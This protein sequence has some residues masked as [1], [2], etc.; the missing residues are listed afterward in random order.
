MLENNP[1]STF[2]SNFCFTVKEN[3]KLIVYI[4]KEQKV[5]QKITLFMKKK[6]TFFFLSNMKKKK[7]TLFFKWAEIW[8]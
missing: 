7:M 6:G 5:K 4:Y 2:I 1:L 3:H 8:H